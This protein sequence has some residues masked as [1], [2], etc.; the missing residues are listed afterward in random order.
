M[1][2]ALFAHPRLAAIYDHL[3]GLRDDLDAYLALAE[4]VGARSVLDVGCGTG[5]L[6]CLLAGR[7]LEVAG[8]DPAAA[9][10]AVARGKAGA[11]RVRWLEGDAT[12]LPPL[13]V[14]LATM[15]G[16]VAQVLLTDP[17]WAAALRGIG[18]ALRPGGWLAFETRVPEREAWRGWTRARTHRLV[19]VPTAGPVETWVDLTAVDPPLISFRHTYRFAADGAC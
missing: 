11:D 5:T 9:S 14:D 16:N 8:V 2:D 12:T 4:E 7:G 13:Q 6:A 18:E 15:T 17:G 10:L 19:E 1:A 3:D